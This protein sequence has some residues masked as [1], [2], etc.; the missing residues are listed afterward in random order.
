M[1]AWSVKDALNAI[2][3]PHPSA[4]RFRR[5]RCEAVALS[6][7]ARTSRAVTGWT[8]KTTEHATT[9]FV[10]EAVTSIDPAS[11]DHIDFLTNESSSCR[12]T[13]VDPD[14]RERQW[15]YLRDV[16]LKEGVSKLD[17]LDQLVTAHV[18]DGWGTDDKGSITRCWHRRLGQN[19]QQEQG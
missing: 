12:G 17:L 8:L 3:L 9:R 13:A 4:T 7:S 11:I 14:G 5:P 1:V 6:G 19:V 18:G 10:D 16:W 2:A 15:E